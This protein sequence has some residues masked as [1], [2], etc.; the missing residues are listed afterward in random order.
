MNT[1][2]LKLILDTVR[3]V[4]QTA[5]IVG[6]FWVALHYLVQLATVL[7]APIA[8][9]FAVARVAKYVHVWLVAKQTQPSGDTME[10]TKHEAMRLEAEKV[11]AQASEATAQLREIATA[12][13]ID[14]ML[15]SKLYSSDLNTII[16][17]LKGKA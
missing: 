10:R 17:R 6:V 1:E 8:T 16:G 11:K 5:G 3:E 2:E 13:G 15:A 7:A 14:T 4:S 12:A 9:A